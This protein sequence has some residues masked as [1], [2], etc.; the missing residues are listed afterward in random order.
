MKA[1]YNLI[2]VDMQNGFSAAKDKDTLNQVMI[3]I[4]TAISDCAGI[5]VLEMVGAGKT[6]KQIKK[7]VKSYRKA[8]IVEKKDTSGAVEVLSTVRHNRSFHPFKFKVCGVYTD[9]CVADTVNELSQFDTLSLEVLA[10]ACNCDEPAYLDNID[11]FQDDGLT[12]DPTLA[13][14]PRENVLILW[15]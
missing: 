13:I 15:K 3:E 8:V 14:I 4:K 5:I 9:C 2:V 1:P 6:L 7:L 10:D 12:Y 11:M